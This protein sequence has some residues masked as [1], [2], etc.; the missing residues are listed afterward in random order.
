MTT[1]NNEMKA[2]HKLVLVIAVLTAII[3]PWLYHDRA[4]IE[5][6]TE[7]KNISKQVTELDG[8][9]RRY[10]FKGNISAIPDR[11]EIEPQ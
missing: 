5:L 3:A 7:M 4:I 9:M 10:I 6:K 2:L 11:K 1:I 8:L